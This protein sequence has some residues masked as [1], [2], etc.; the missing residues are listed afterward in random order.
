VLSNRLF[1]A[2]IATALLALIVASPLP[3]PAGDTHYT[4]YGK[5]H[6]SI[7]LLDN[8]DDASAF[9]SSN[10]TRVGIMGHY[11]LED[12][13]YAIW[14]YEVRADFHTSDDEQLS[15]RNSYVGLKG[16]FGRVIA[17]RH[18]TPFKTLGREVDFFVDRVGD[19]RNATRYVGA[20]GWDERIAA[21]V[22]YSTPNLNGFRA[23]ALWR[24][25]QGTDGNELFSVGAWFERDG[26]LVGA[27]VETHGKAMTPGDKQETGFRMAAAYETDSFEVG[28][29]VQ[30][31]QDVDGVV[32]RESATVGGGAA[33]YPARRWAL[34]GQVYHVDP[35]RETGD[36][37]L[38]VAAAVDRDLSNR[39]T[40]Y[41]AYAAMTNDEGSGMWA[42]T[43]GGHG[44][45]YPYVDG[46]LVYQTRPGETGTAVSLGLIVVW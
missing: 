33:W 26:L 4:I 5:A 17:G 41:L 20:F 24:P 34:R 11:E 46:D 28:G 25:E 45:Q 44:V 29:L 42:P 15:G 40:L 43:R 32:D 36:E 30:F 2:V 19:S 37:G 7:D 3:A 13:L 10:L 31:L 38:L 18:D 12:R 1:P 35:D 23:H 8:G 16:R 9:V 27:A 21:M 14:R 39:V 22:M 6:V